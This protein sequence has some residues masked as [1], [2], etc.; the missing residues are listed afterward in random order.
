M[1]RFFSHLLGEDP[2]RVARMYPSGRRRVMT[3]GGALLVPVLLWFVSTVL[4]VGQ[5]MAEPLWIAALAALFAASLIFL[6]ERSIVMAPGQS[7]FLFGFRIALGLLIAVLGSLSLDEVI[8]RKDIDRKVAELKSADVRAAGTAA[9]AEM[10]EDVVARQGQVSGAYEAWQQALR[11]VRAEADGTG[12]SRRA[13]VGPIVRLKQEQADRLE[14]LW[15]DEQSKLQELQARREGDRVAGEAGA[16]AAFDSHGLLVRVKALFALVFE[17]RLMGAFYL[18]FTLLLVCLE[19]IV[20][21][22]KTVYP[23]TTDEQLESEGEALVLVRAQRVAQ[24]VREHYTGAEGM[25]ESRLNHA[26][27]SRP[28]SRVL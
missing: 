25:P 27:L 1:L 6:I 9:T 17:D 18:L 11:E 14:Q 12:G 26:L 22:L 21:I 10:E 16:E 3:L 4:L 24:K 7:R 2:D 19:F 15:K 5:V 28:Q 23:L 13:K 8:F 20:I